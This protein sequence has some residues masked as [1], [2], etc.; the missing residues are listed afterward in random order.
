[1]IDKYDLINR[2]EYSSK[3]NTPVSRWVIDVVR[4]APDVEIRCGRCRHCENREGY[5]YCSFMEVYV[6]VEDYCSKGENR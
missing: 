1:M 2:L 6:T 5:H 3:W 4:N